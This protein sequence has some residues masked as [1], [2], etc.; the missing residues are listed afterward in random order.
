MFFK[1]NLIKGLLVWIPICIT[2]WIINILISIVE[3]K[4]TY[5]I[6]S[7]NVIGFY[8]PGFKIM[9][10][11]TIIYLTGLLKTNLIFK[12]LYFYF[13]KILSY[14][15]LVNSIYSTTKQIS[16]AILS[17]NSQAFRKVILLEYPP[18]S[19]YWVLAFLTGNTSENI[20]KFLNNNKYINVYIPT[21]PNPTSGFFVMVKSSDVIDVNINVD[22]ALKYI[23]SM[24][25]V[26]PNKF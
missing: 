19:Q 15:P 22:Q 17:P 2:I 21:T 25:T 7:T 23:I 9:I 5:F 13:D 24:G 14:I 8:I 16:N 3:D 10:L 26:I 4:I 6:S 18:K 11:L 1:K 20:S 12:N